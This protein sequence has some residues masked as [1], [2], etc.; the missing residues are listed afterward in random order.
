LKQLIPNLATSLAL[1]LA[2]LLASTA[3][4]SEPLVRQPLFKI[5]RSKNANIIQYDAQVG[6]DGKLDAKTP[7]VAYWIRLADQG[8]IRKLSWI[9]RTFAFGFHAHYDPVTD[10]APMNMVV[11]I[12]RD[13]AVVRDGDVYR[14]KTI[15]DG[16]PSYLD[17]IYIE[18]HKSGLLI[19]VEFVDIYGR[20]VI[21]GEK[22]YEHFVP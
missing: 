3:L 18:A 16:A 10:T 1:I 6:P 2:L 19:K 14:A 4:C 5:E 15:I 22:R 20:D 7:V 17:R 21:T 12:D 13:I 9:Q 8:E 11:D